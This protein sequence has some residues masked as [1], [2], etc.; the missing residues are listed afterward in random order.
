MNTTIVEMLG[1]IAK[2]FAV[3][4]LIGLAVSIFTIVLIKKLAKRAEL[5]ELTYVPMTL[6]ESK[7]WKCVLIA[8]PLL[9]GISLAVF[10][11]LKELM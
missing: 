7:L 3:G 5:Y 9:F 10:Y 6:V 4:G 2:T 8:Y 11:L 1:H